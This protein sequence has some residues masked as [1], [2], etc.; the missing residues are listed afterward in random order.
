MFLGRWRSRVQFRLPFILGLAY[1]VTYVVLL[2]SSSVLA[3]LGGHEACV[4][5]LFIGG[6]FF[7]AVLIPVGLLADREKGAP[8]G[9]D[10][11]FGRLRLLGV[12]VPL[13][14]LALFVSVKFSRFGSVDYGILMALALGVGVFDVFR[15]VA[16]LC[17]CIFRRDM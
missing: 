5:V 1:A 13:Y 8:G 3:Y 12:V 11:L 14:V 6:L 10:P 7:V 15:R 4:S 9:G 16:F 2:F 17:P